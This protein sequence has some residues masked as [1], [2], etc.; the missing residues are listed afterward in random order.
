MG[1]NEPAGKPQPASVAIVTGTAP[2]GKAVWWGR[3]RVRGLGLGFRVPAVGFVSQGS[4][5]WDSGKPE[6]PKRR[7]CRRS[8]K[9]MSPD[10]WVRFAGMTADRRCRY[11]MP[12][13]A[14]QQQGPLLLPLNNTWSGRGGHETRARTGNRPKAEPIVLVPPGDP[15][16]RMDGLGESRHVGPNSPSSPQICGCGGPPCTFGII[17]AVRAFCLVWP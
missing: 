16:G 6:K 14:T 3:R 1:R 5:L 4:S 12:I 11:A 10:V 9:T 8:P 2:A 7:R 17:H 15:C 13:S